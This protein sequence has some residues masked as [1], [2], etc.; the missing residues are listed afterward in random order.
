MTDD[1]SVSESWFRA[2]SGAHDQM[3]ITVWQLLC[4]FRYRAPPSDERLG[5]S[6]DLVTWTA[7]VQC[8]KFPAGP[9]QH[10]DFGS[11]CATSYITRERGCSYCCV[12]WC[13]PCRA[14]P[15]PSNCYVILVTR[16]VVFTVPCRWDCA[17]RTL[18]LR[19][20]LATVVNK[21]SQCWLCWPTT[22]TSQYRI[23]SSLHSWLLMSSRVFLL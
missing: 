5:L 21:H 19:G 6:F 1:Q 15:L 17:R 11:N 4:F 18:L 2:P 7:S 14:H 16:H 23:W 8:S 3:L 9:R 22:C 10:S 20:R 12:T 13:L